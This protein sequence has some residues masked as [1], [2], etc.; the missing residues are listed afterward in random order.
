MMPG[1]MPTQPTATARATR[2]EKVAVVPYRVEDDELQFLLITSRGRSRWLIPKGGLLAGHGPRTS[3]RTEAFEEA[4]VGGP[5]GAKPIGFYRHGQ[6]ASAPLVQVFL[7]RVEKQAESWPE[8]H[9]RRCRWMPAER[10]IRAVG[11]LGLRTILEEAATVLHT[12]VA[13]PRSARARHPAVPTPM[14]RG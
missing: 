11:I 7:M 9:E 1:V 13:N 10:A 8:Q 6:S 5:M 12:V 3:A 4:G 2:A 14:R